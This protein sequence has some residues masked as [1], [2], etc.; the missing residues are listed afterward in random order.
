MNYIGEHLLPGQLGHFFA[1]LS[2]VT[3]LVATVSF[4]KS[5]KS[6]LKPEKEDWMRL[7]KGAFLL[8]TICVVGVISCIYYILANNYFEYKYAWEHSDSTMQ[9]KYIFSCLWEGQEGSF[10]LWSFWHCVLGWLVIWRVKEW[11]APGLT[12]IFFLQFFSTF[13][14]LCFFFFCFL[15]GDQPF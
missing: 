6:V 11:R 15:L 8:E 13:M 1:V 10:L 5:N 14:L 2:L 7:A 3:S 12:L 9:T 4:Y